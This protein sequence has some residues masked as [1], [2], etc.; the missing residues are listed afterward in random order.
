MHLTVSISFVLLLLCSIAETLSIPLTKKFLTQEYFNSGLSY[1]P[2]KCDDRHHN[3]VDMYEL[4]IKNYSG[5]NWSIC[6]MIL[7]SFLKFTGIS[8]V[9]V[10]VIYFHVTFIFKFSSLAKGAECAYRLF[11]KSTCVT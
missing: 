1:S 9:F 8:W 7:S 11:W 5:Y 3:T 4:C 10:D 2:K 6:S